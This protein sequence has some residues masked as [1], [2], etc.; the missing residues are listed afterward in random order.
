M[1]RFGDDATYWFE[2]A[3]A[4]ATVLHLHRGTPYIYQGEEL[5][6]TNV[7]FDDIASFRD[8]ES[9]NYYAEA[10]AS[11]RDPPRC[12]APA[13]DE[14]RQRAHPDAVVRAA[15]AGFTTGTPWIAVNPNHTEINAER[16]RS[17]R[18]RCT[19]TTGG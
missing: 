15:H 4:L 2:S 18:S 8:I 6:M 17:I 19:I 5:G 1:S 10:V 13:S 3:T 12:C 7:P 9:L 14:P 11:W 16:R